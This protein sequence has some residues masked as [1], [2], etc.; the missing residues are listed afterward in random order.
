MI[1]RIKYLIILAIIAITNLFLY[2]STITEMVDYYIYDLFTKHFS[3]PIEPQTP[4]TIVINIDDRS[5]NYLGQWPWPRIIEAKL[6]NMINIQLPPAIGINILFSELDRTSPKNIKEFYRDIL[7]INVS[8]NGINLIEDNDERLIYS[9]KNANAV[10]PILFQSNTNPNDNCQNLIYKN[11]ILKDFSTTFTTNSALCNHFKLQKSIKNFGFMNISPDSD[12]VFRR[13]YL[14]GK[15]KNRVLPSFGLAVLMSIDGNIEILNSHSF[16]ILGHRVDMNRD[17]SV[18]INF[19]TTPPKIISVIDVLNNR[20]SPKEFLGKIVLIGS[21]ITASQPIYKLSSGRAITNNIINGYLIQNILTDKLFVQPDF[22][23]M[24]N[25]LIATL[26]SLII[27]LL[28]VKRFYILILTIF[29]ATIFLSTFYTYVFFEKNIYISLGY[30]LTPFIS[31]FFV[32]NFFFI[33][34]NI[35]D[36]NQFYEELLKSHSSAVES[37]ALISAIRDDETGEH[38]QRTKIYIKELANYLLKHKKY[39]HIL[40]KRY[41]N[42]I[43]Q[44][45]PLH[46]IG[47]LGIPDSI[48]K[49]PAKLTKEE[50]EIMKQHPILAKNAIEKAMKYYDKNDFLNIAYNIA[51][52]HHERW[53]GSGYPV[54]LKGDEIPLEAQLMAIADVYDALVTKR[55]YKDEFSFDKAEEIIVEGAE[56]QFNPL[57]VEAFIALRYRFREIARKYRDG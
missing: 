19:N 4:T 8:L 17:S 15:Y 21:A 2:N 23:K 52:Y 40:N 5:I 42:L 24:L 27:I 12:G 7:D 29:F 56:T 13:V 6:I 39:T 9:I 41:I 25:M 20:V 33:I 16:K 1:K 34:I 47:K 32:I 36:K 46:D 35:K 44:A 30:L 14:F 18:L 54:G 43:Y 49:K 55:Y 28:L 10:L 26:L 37:I 51:Y 45:A 53:D 48:L 11:N 31:H 50:Y 3:K 57:L 22:F 38:L